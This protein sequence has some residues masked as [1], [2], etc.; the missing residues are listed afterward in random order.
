MSKQAQQDRDHYIIQDYKAQT[1][2]KSLA[3]SNGLTDR[4]IMQILNGHGVEIRPR[5]KR[6]EIEPISKQHE[7]IGRSIADHMFDNEVDLY[8]A[9]NALGWSFSKLRKTIEGITDIELLD[10]MDIASYTNRT[11]AQVMSDV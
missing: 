1:S 3:R 8:E 5:P 4:R 10:L 11:V 6:F 7:R 9:S 2:V